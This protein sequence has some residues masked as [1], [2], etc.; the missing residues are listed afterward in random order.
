MT[1]TTKPSPAYRRWH[2]RIASGTFTHSQCRAYASLVARILAGYEP[3][4]TGTANGR[5]GRAT[6]L[7]YEEAVQLAGEIMDRGGMNLT[8]EHTAIGRKWLDR[9][10]YKLADYYGN[11]RAFPTADVREHFERFVYRGGHVGVD[12][13]GGEFRRSVP[14]WHVELDDGRELAYFAEAWQGDPAIAGE[15]WWVRS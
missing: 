14:V 5:R 13:W 4:G 9:Y 2:D 15:W 7:T 1:T 3:A 6:T 8:A 12:Y 10:G 11:L